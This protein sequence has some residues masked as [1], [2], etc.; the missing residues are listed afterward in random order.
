MLAVAM[1]DHYMHFF[2]TSFIPAVTVGTSAAK[3]F[4]QFLPNDDFSLDA[5][6]VPWD[7]KL[8]KYMSPVNT[9]NLRHCNVS[10][11]NEG[12][13]EVMETYVGLFHEKA[14]RRFILKEASSWIWP[15][16]RILLNVTTQMRVSVLHKWQTLCVLW[17]IS[18]EAFANMATIVHRSTD[19][20]EIRRDA[21]W[22][23]AWL[24]QPGLGTIDLE[25]MMTHCR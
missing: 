24:S 6:I 19:L 17:Y 9:V 15:L 21:G 4:Q 5:L 3:A 18:C 14:T 23:S 11:G 20:R 22:F 1:V 2:D 16:G 10:S 25:L 12:I 8:L 7:E 13:I